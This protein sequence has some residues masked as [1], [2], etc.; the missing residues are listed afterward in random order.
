MAGETHMKNIQTGRSAY[1]L[2]LNVTDNT[3]SVQLFIRKLFI[4]ILFIF[5][6][7]YLIRIRLLYIKNDMDTNMNLILYFIIGIQNKSYVVK[8]CF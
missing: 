6:Y 8:F 7:T 1:E 2:N 3:H 4:N 5:E